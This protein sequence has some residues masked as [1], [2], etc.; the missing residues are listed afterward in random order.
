MKRSS[1]TTAVVETTVHFAGEDIGVGYAVG[2]ITPQHMAERLEA[3]AGAGDID[4]DAPD[5][6]AKVSSGMRSLAEQVQDMVAWWDVT[7][8]DGNRLEPTV[9]VALTLPLPFLR[10]VVNAA[11]EAM[12]PPTDGR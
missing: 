11:Q 2:K 3:L 9:E 7:D 8:D 12:R 1:M 4:E 6:V 10:V 5:A